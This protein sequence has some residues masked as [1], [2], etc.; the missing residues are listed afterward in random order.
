MTDVA[1]DVDWFTYHGVD[2]A[3]FFGGCNTKPYARFEPGLEAK[4]ICIFAV[5]DGFSFGNTPACVL[6]TP[7]VDGPED[8]SSG[9]VFGCCDP[10][11]VQL[12]YN[13][14]FTT[15][16]GTIYLRVTGGDLSCKAYKLDHGYGME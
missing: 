8:P 6:G 2:A 14:G 10:K 9:E 5:P 16:S 7:S 15:D 11:E 4:E 12:D 13:S 3:N 1:G